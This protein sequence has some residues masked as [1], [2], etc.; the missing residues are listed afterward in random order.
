MLSCQFFKLR[1][2]VAVIDAC[3]AQHL[4]L[5][6]AE[7]LALQVL[8]IP[9]LAQVWSA[10]HHQQSRHWRNAGTSLPCDAAQRKAPSAMCPGSQR[11]WIDCIVQCSQL[12][13]GDLRAS[14]E[15]LPAG[16]WPEMPAQRPTAAETKG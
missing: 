4:E 1:C 13:L 5:K 3:R 7:H 2:D 16:L 9:K 12:T 8:S 14:L 10:A 15:I 11:I 6:V